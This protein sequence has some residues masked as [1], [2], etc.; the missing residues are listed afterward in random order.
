MSRDVVSEIAATGMLRAAIN[1][2]NFLLVTGTSS[3]GDP[4]GVGP[5]M[6]RAIA[7][8][9]GVGV[10]YVTYPSPGELA[11]AV[12]RDAWDIGLIG[13]EPARAEKIAFT[14]AYVEIEATY[15]V[16]P[17]SSL[18]TVA[19][20]DRPGV[21]IAVSGRSAYDLYLAR[22]LVHA[23]LVRA[24][25]IDASFDLFVSEGLDAL[26]GLRPALAK[27]AGRL[28][29]SR[30][31][32]GRFTAVQQAVGTRRGNAASVAFLRGFV[33]EAKS[34][35]LVAELIRRHGVAG[36]LSVAPPA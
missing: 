10:S 27:A 2:S 1:L 11:D 13:D 21:R 32:E 20:I 5:D 19:D 17:G 9:L 23:E 3:E 30:V 6:A 8:R 25:G 36:R 16:P 22:S 34:R 15:L 4:V 33:E 29:G 18:T 28:A 35:G 7:D 26:A 12:D 14:P 24:R 31:L